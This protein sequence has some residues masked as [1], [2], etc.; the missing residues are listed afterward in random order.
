MGGC[1]IVVDGSVSVGG[2]KLL[3]ST[4][5]GAKDTVDAVLLFAGFVANVAVEVVLLFAASR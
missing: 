1:G 5:F 2:R 3:V 4:G